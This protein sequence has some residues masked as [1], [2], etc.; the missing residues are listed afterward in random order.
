MAL[1]YQASIQAGNKALVEIA[2][3][4]GWGVYVTENSAV[5]NPQQLSRFKA[6]I[7]D[8]VIGDVLKRSTKRKAFKD[9]IEGGGSFIGIHRRA[10]GFA[11]R[12]KWYAD[13][14]I[15]ALFTGHT[16]WPH[17]QTATVDIADPQHPACGLLRQKEWV[18]RDGTGLISANPVRTKGYRIL[19]MLD[20][21]TDKPRGLLYFSDIAMHGER[22]RDPAT[23]SAAAGFVLALGHDA[24][25][26]FSFP[27]HRQM[28]ENTMQWSASDGDCKN[29]L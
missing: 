3:K 28:L 11:T 26:P 19:V 9:Y 6:V 23:A 5:F 2:Q 24:E 27:L 22:R 21:L 14:V 8:S 4:R 29:G 10:R 17:L 16:I 25:V 7:W 13:E 12:G 1:V 15:G 20:E 18:T